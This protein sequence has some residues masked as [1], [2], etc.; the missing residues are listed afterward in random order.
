MDK[1]LTDKDLAEQTRLLIIQYMA[2]FDGKI[3]AAWYKMCQAI[4]KDL[5]DSDEDNL[6]FLCFHAGACEGSLINNKVWT[7]HL[8][9]NNDK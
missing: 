4:E 7:E 2:E 5:G 3:T 1:S 9:L 8:R 6:Y